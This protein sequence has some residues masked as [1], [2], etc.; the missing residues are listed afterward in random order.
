MKQEDRK[1]IRLDEVTLMRTILALLIVFMHSFTCYNGS[2][3]QPAG[4]V[5]IPLYKWLQRVSFAFT[6]ETFVFISG[7]LF[8]FQRI[9]LKRTGG[10][11]NLIV[12]KLKR[13]ILPSIIFS[14]IYFLLFYEYKGLGNAVYSIINGCGHMWY[15]PMLFWCFV[16]G[17]LLEQIKIKDGWKMAFLVVL[18]LIPF[19][20][21]PLRI[22]TSFVF[23]AYFYGGFLFYKNRE[24]I[25]SWVTL[26]TLIVSWV[27]FIILFAVMRPLRDVLAP[28]SSFS[29]TQKVIVLVG[30][31]FCQ[32][33]YASVGLIAFYGTAVYYIQHHQL[34][35]AT[36]KI[37]AC[38]FGIYLFQQF[39]LQLLYYK[40]SFP[41]LVGPYWLPWCGFVIAAVVSYVLSV[42]L[43]KTKVGKFLIG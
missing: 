7:Y 8:A 22:F 36:K 25:T 35:E 2:W 5:D 42:L 23:M 16:F 10:W 21:L 15:L 9:T 27:F 20:N 28:D 37:A 24:R 38:C 11:I 43:L 30:N 1:R 18:N 41:L 33:L 32:L 14:I 6:L 17:W 29:V 19:P 13:L 12:N 26:R 40:T 39:V 4:Y 34:S 3:E 31:H